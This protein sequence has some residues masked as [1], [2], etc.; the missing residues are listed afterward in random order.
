MDILT[1]LESYHPWNEQ[2]IRDREELLRRLR[3]GEE[4]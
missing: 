1:E 2:E 3:S 4:L